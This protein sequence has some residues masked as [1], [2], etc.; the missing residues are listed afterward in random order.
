MK[1]T[2]EECQEIAGAIDSEGF[3]YYFT[4]YGADSRL[5]NLISV[6]IKKFK[7]ASAEL[8]QALRDIGVE[9]E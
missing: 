2:E 4:S 9:I 6:Q 3:H 1:L 5:E 7:S 8:E